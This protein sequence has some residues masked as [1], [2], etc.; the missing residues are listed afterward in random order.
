[1]R[2]QWGDLILHFLQNDTV[3]LHLSLSLRVWVGVGGGLHVHACGAQR[4][5]LSVILQEPP[6]PSFFLRQGLSLA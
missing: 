6:T 4:T 5:A 3:P 1:M 2:M